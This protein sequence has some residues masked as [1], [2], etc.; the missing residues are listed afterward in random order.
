M[1]RRISTQQKAVLT[2]TDPQRTK[3]YLC[4][5]AHAERV[6]YICVGVYIAFGIVRQR[7]QTHDSGIMLK[8]LHQPVGEQRIRKVVLAKLRL[9][10]TIQ[11]PEF[12]WAKM[13]NTVTAW[14]AFD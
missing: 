9:C 6:L 1:Q 8:L 13:K 3:Y 4:C 7:A 5:V 2:T 11:K 14:H 10:A 12:V